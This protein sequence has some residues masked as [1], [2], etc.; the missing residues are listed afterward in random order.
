MVSIRLSP[1]EHREFQRMCASKG[2][3]SI[4]DLARTAMHRLVASENDAD[5]L[6]YEVQDLRNQAQFI[7]VELERIGKIMIARKSAQE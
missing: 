7:L 6:A 5:L 4:S 1:D 2:I 3:R